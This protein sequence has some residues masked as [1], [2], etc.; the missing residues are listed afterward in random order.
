MRLTCSRSPLRA[1]S[2]TW[3]RIW[4]CWPIRT[5]RSSTCCASCGR[6]KAIRLTGPSARKDYI[7]TSMSRQTAV[8]CLVP[9]KQTGHVVY[10]TSD[11][12]LKNHSR[13]SLAAPSSIAA[14]ILR[15]TSSCCLA[16]ASLSS[17]DGPP[18]PCPCPCPP[19]DEPPEGGGAGRRPAG[20]WK[21]DM[22]RVWFNVVTK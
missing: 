1:S 5:R 21:F 14:I 8:S 3:P 18:C 16:F 7:T 11:I 22:L 9:T 15:L 13:L 19:G 10:G 2:E 17:F 20:S 12:V 4:P 6:V